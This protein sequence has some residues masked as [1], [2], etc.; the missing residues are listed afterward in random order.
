[1]ALLETWKS[2]NG[3]GINATE[4]GF[5]SFAPLSQLADGTDLKQVLEAIVAKTGPPIAA[6][7]RVLTS[8]ETCK[9]VFAPWLKTMH[10]GSFKDVLAEQLRILEYNNFELESYKDFKTIMTQNVTLLAESGV[11]DEWEQR[12]ESMSYLVGSQDM[13]MD[14]PSSFW[15]NSLMARVL[16]ILIN[17]DAIPIFPWEKLLLPIGAMPGVPTMVKFPPD[18][19][20]PLHNAR[21]AVLRQL[22]EHKTVTKWKE[23]VEKNQKSYFR[24]QTTFGLDFTFL[25]E[26]V[27]GLVN[28]R[29]QSSIIEA[30]PSSSKRR[31]Y[32]EV[33]F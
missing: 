7:R 3:D 13:I 12:L 17:S 30:L 4:F 16:E 28:E 31:S 24:F 20:L 11:L 23:V 19:V 8:S 33:S 9:H 25:T 18:V 14:S 10:F 29:I 2:S 5:A 27:E 26:K 1:M 32:V 22:G 6:L 15:L 21:S